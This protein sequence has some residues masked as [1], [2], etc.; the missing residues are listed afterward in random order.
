MIAFGD[1]KYNLL[2]HGISKCKILYK[3]QF[4]LQKDKST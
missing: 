4:G 3:K 1:F 2:N